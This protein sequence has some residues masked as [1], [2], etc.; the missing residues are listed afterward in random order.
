[1]ADLSTSYATTAAGYVALAAVGY[2]VYYMSTQKSRQKA[3]ATQ[4]KPAAKTSQPEP[5]KEDRKKK[6]RL[7]SF[8]SE[9]QASKNKSH[10]K[11]AEPSVAAQDQKTEK[12]V[13]EDI[14]NK[15]FA[16]QLSQAKQGK[17][18][19]GGSEPG[20]KQKEKS[21]K[22]SRAQEKV[23]KPVAAPVP[24][25]IEPEPVNEVSDDAAE[26]TNDPSGV[27]DMLEP[28]S[29]APSVLRLTDTESK[30]KPKKVAKAAEPAETKKQRQ[31]RKKAEAAKA[32]REEAETERK[33]LEEKQ[34]RAA[35]VAEGRSAK[36]G[37]Q[38]TAAA[39]KNS[40]WNQ[41]APN[42]E[43]A[44]AAPGTN[45]NH[46]LLDTFEAPVESSP[47][48]EAPKSAPKAKQS[49]WVSSLPSEEEQMKQ[50]QDADEWN[51]VTT[52]SSK[53]SAKKAT[54]SSGDEAAAQ[55]SAPAPAQ[56]PKVQE[57]AAAPKTAPQ[58]TKSK[59]PQAFGSF[60]ALSTKDDPAEEVEEEWD[61]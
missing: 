52:K 5:R 16:R 19:T 22:Q 11:A 30:S 2:G 47:A 45:G 48:V 40:A 46:E 50:L 60:S 41:G 42:G 27:A 3:A 56:A 33:T 6:Q 58:P 7:E 61:V 9:T 51:T 37:S 10:A 25:A 53:R 39:V 59:G 1:M 23:A 55:P 24:A 29:A 14:D 26:T 28:A 49:D 38:F 17:S 18:F 57:A 54:S 4:S 35:R 31:N 36:D 34:R 21:V 43:K 12:V 20:K 44:A 8:T 13:K 32:A 15:E